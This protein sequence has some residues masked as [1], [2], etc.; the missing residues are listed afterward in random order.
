[1]ASILAYRADVD[2]ADLIRAV[3]DAVAKPVN[4]SSRSVHPKGRTPRFVLFWRGS[5]SV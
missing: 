2:V 1:M 3:C 4:S 5:V